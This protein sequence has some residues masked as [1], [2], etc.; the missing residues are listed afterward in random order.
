M[1]TNFNVFLAVKN[2]YGKDVDL[3]SE[4]STSEEEDEDAV[5]SIKKL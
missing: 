1:F 3:G 5:V 4:S 2:K